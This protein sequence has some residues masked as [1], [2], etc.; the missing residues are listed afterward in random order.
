[1][2]QYL[3]GQQYWW[4]QSE[5]LKSEEFNKKNAEKCGHTG[6]KQ[7]SKCGITVQ[8]PDNIERAI[9]QIRATQKEIRSILKQ[10]KAKHEELNCQLAATHVL[11]GK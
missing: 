4:K 5:L 8:Y 9:T 3:E 1:M 10:A 7:V 2:W 11:T 6:H